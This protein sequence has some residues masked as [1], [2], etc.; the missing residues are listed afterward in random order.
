MGERIRKEIKTG[1][2]SEGTELKREMGVWQQRRRSRG[3]VTVRGGY[4]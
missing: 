2:G 3:K 1:K 4:I